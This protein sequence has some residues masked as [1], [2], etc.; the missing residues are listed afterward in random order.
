MIEQ[1]NIGNVALLR[2]CHGKANVL[3][4]EFLK[5]ISR[6][7]DDLARSDVGAVV[8]TGTGN[9]FSAG[10]DLKR[11]EAG[12]AEYIQAFIPALTEVFEKMF[13]FPHPL[14]AA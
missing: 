13:F 5:G 12:G 9:I 8:I 3:D 10:V 14:L 6:T 2:M 11:L 1:E 4:I 7:F